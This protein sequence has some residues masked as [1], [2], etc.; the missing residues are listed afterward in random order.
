MCYAEELTLSASLRFH[1]VYILGVLFHHANLTATAFICLALLM[2]LKPINLSSALIGV[3]YAYDECMRFKTT[4]NCCSFVF[5]IELGE[6]VLRLIPPFT[7]GIFAALTYTT[8]GNSPYYYSR[9]GQL[10]AF[11]QIF[12]SYLLT[13]FMLLHQ[14]FVLSAWVAGL[15]LGIVT[16]SRPNSF[17]IQ[18]L[19]SQIG[20]SAVFFGATCVN[21][22]FLG[23]DCCIRTSPDM[24]KYFILRQ[25]WCMLACLEFEVICFEAEIMKELKANRSQEKLLFQLKSSVDDSFFRMLPMKSRR[26]IYTR[27][28]SIFGT[29][30][31]YFP[32][33]T[34]VQLLEI[35]LSQ[36]ADPNYK[37][38]GK[39]HVLEYLFY[40][41]KPKVLILLD[42][43]DFDYTCKLTNG[44]S[45]SEM[46]AAVKDSSETNAAVHAFVSRKLTD[47]GLI[48]LAHRQQQLKGF[49][50]LQTSV[51]L[52]S[53]KYL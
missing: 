39:L 8:E 17:L 37:K 43:F 34:L 47:I 19:R 12:P 36:G 51:L 1:S 45:F 23:L 49:N 18:S 7:I 42:R 44:R 31:N 41:F 2:R 9:T 33:E 5:Y 16:S 30:Y 28:F 48:T 29:H 14:Y 25:V 4:M 13:F 24:W 38:S 3:F 6:Q 52:E 27:L 22:M 46:A 53:F 10:A 50:R 11:W 26:R 15:L 35:C 20:H 40:N 21:L 32:E